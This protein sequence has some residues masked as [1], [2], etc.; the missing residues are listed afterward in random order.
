MLILCDAEEDHDF[1]STF[2]AE[3]NETNYNII[4]DILE[5]Q[6]IPKYHNYDPI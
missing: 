4:I 5:N 2:I 3:V 1:Y 6:F